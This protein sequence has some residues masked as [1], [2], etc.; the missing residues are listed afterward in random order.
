MFLCPSPTRA[1]SHTL[2]PP[3]HTSPKSSS[4][5]AKNPLQTLYSTLAEGKPPSTHL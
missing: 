1:T 5:K 2:I 4:L 3:K